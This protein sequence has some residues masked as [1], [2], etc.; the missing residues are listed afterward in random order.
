MDVSWAELSSQCPEMP[1]PIMPKARAGG[2]PNSGQI[3][4]Q[5]AQNGLPK[6][7]HKILVKTC[8][9]DSKNACSNLAY[10]LPARLARRLK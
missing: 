1:T 6:F 7:L 8:L 10:F 9:R 5:E 2:L 4:V 3:V